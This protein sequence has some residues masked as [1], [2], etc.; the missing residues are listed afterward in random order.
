MAT[1]HGVMTLLLILAGPL[2]AQRAQ[3]GV[4]GRVQEKSAIGAGSRNPTHVL[5]RRVIGEIELPPNP[6]QVERERLRAAQ[7]LPLPFSEDQTHRVVRRT[8]SQTA[9][10]PLAGVIETAVLYPRPRPVY[11]GASLA[12]LLPEFR[13]PDPRQPEPTVPNRWRVGFPSWQRYEDAG[14]DAPYARQRRWDPFNRNTIKGDYPIFGRHTFLNFTGSS[15]TLAESRRVPTASNVS[16]GDSGS[17]NFFGRG[18]QF[19][20]RQDFRLSLDLFR[21]SAAFEPVSWEVRFTPQFNINYLLARELGVVNIDVRQG[22]R[23]T[24]DHA[25]VQELFFEKRLGTN[26]ASTFRRAT[27]TDDRGNPYYDFTSIR[28][29]IQRFTS[30]FRGFIFSDEQPGAR[31]FGNLKNNRL[32][33]NL[34][35]FNMLEKDTNS[36]LNTFERR[37]Q[38]VSIANLYWQ[39][40]LAQGYTGQFSLHY[41]NDQP[42]FHLDR[43]G[44]L[45]R[46][47]PI[48][49][50]Q[51]HKI[52]AGYA[53][54]AGDGHFGRINVS[55][56]FYQAFGRD[57]FN[58]IKDHPLHINAQLAALELSYDRD[59]LRYKASFFYSSGDSM[60]DPGQA[61]GFDSIVDNQNFA[62]G[63][64]L[65]NGLFADRGQTNPLFE[66]GGIN[67][68]NRQGIPLTGTG[69]NLVSSNSLM[70]TL[71]SSK[72]E[73]QA[74]FVN[75]GIMIFNAGADA[76]ITPKLKSTFNLNYLR[77]DRTES[78]EALLFQSGIKHE[79]GWDVGLG[80]QYKPLLSENVVVTSGVSI[81]K[82]GDGFKSI[83]TG[84]T[85][86]SGFV[87]VRLL[88]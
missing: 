50:P 3:I 85:L 46:P 57:D 65:N 4:K 21:G 75:P 1:R 83:Y 28:V 47:Q 69:V 6:N 80:V 15:D 32:Q 12:G 81:L 73:G 13:I 19:S 62:G 34:A 40:F 58:P 25:G 18:E 49:D 56:A 55:N 54:F 14:I 82:P 48:G 36:G 30:D 33:Y 78:L 64:F 22:L 68:F 9:P 31:L 11:D 77:F 41:N 79:I 5:P 16:A 45:V 88:F 74:N 2:V 84:Q 20:V 70:P 24:D 42:T 44:F 71:R 39:D 60:A 8:P 87:L 76:K 51:P 38:T 7:P 35:Y 29:G 72:D 23:R 26:S 37:H 67:L 10:A 66:G 43:N 53:G 86:Y 59:W 63:G 52:R 17:F 27:D 61:R